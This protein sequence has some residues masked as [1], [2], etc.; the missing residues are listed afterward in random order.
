MLKFYSKGE[1]TIVA[2]TSAKAGFGLRLRDGT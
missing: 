2:C 1:S